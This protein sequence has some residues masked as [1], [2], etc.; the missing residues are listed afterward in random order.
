MNTKSP[1]K[2][3]EKLGE[4][5]SADY[6]EGES[7]PPEIR[8]LVTI[9]GTDGDVSMCPDC[10]TLYRS[11]RKTDNDIYNLI[12]YAELKRITPV[13]LDSI[14]KSERTRILGIES[15][16]K[17]FEKK[18][19]SKFGAKKLDVLPENERK[20][21]QYLMRKTWYGEYQ[22]QLERQLELSRETIT[23]LLTK[24]E[25]KGILKRKIFWPLSPGK[26]NFQEEQTDG[27]P[28]PYTKFS[29]DDS[30]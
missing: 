18:V 9:P 19:K 25:K 11:S 30:R 17:K 7:L 15:E 12:D 2:I 29:I 21:V 1:C 6:L 3:C 14:L 16:I 5:V 24:L 27:D 23:P 22:E 13:E 20:I 28:I 4:G 26:Y 10:G 8:Q